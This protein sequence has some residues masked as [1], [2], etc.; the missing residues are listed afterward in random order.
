M[1]D[2]APLY[3]E[4]H[5]G[6]LRPA[7]R[8]A[9]EAMREINGTV[10]AVLT[11]G[12]ANQRRRSLYWVLVSIVTPILNDMHNMTLTDDDLHDIMRDKLGMFDE[13]RLPSGEVHRKRHSTSNRAMN[14]ADRA[15][16]LNN[17]I[18]I[19][20]KW[21]GIEPTTLTAEGQRAA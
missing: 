10:K 8:A 11:G 7:N 17:C 18:S 2:R 13:V 20:S 14:E 21:T 4:T 15:D 6:M 1:A 19:W 9:E 16:Y 12:K 5:L 3:F